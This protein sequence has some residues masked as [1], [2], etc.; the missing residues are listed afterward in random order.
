ML[1]RLDHFQLMSEAPERLVAFYQDIMGMSAEAID[2][3]LWLCQGPER[4]LLIGRGRSNSLGFGA[5]R[6]ETP[7]VRPGDLRYHARW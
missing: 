4:R 6:C 2:H 5:Y 7:D 3:D 1:A